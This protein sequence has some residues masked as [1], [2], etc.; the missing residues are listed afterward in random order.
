MW[1]VRDISNTTVKVHA[2]KSTSRAIGAESLGSLAEKLELAGKS[3]DEAFLDAELA[4]LS[5]DELREAYSSI[6]ECALYALDYLNGFRFFES[7]TQKVEQ[8][9]SAVNDFDWDR[10]NEILGGIYHDKDN[11]AD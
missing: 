7:D 11:F 3:G 2:L 1:R 8:L 5:E 9:Q 6:R 4:G 10:V